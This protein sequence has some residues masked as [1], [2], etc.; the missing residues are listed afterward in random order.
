M[1]DIK[2]SKKSSVSPNITTLALPI[3]YLVVLI[4]VAVISL[5]TGF[6]QI[7]KQR[8]SL[9]AAKQSESVLNE[10]Y[11]TLQDAQGF[12]SQYVDPASNALPDGNPSLYLVSQLKQMTGVSPVV[13]LD[14]NLGKGTVAGDLSAVSVNFNIAGS[15]NDVISFYQELSK[16]A[17]MIIFNAFDIS[18]DSASVSVETRAESYYSDYPDQLPPITQPISKIS[19]SEMQILEEISTL[20]PPTFT[21]LDPSGPFTRENPFAI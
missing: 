17:P 15:V 7:T 12:I 14:L 1:T 9:A 10:K 11:S 13:V 18:G 3:I 19:S 20:T 2:L 21:K 8:R 4:F 5:K 16:L 6:T